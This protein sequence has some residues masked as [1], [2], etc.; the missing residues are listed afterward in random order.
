MCKLPLDEE[1][2]TLTANRTYDPDPMDS[3]R[4]IK[5]RGANSRLLG[6]LRELAA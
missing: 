3:Y 5:S 2:E 1:M 4:R 6:I